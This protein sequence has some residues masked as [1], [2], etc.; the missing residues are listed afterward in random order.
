MLSSET[1]ISIFSEVWDKVI[2]LWVFTCLGP[3]PC[4]SEFTFS[5]NSLSLSFSDI[6]VFTEVWH[7][8][9]FWWALWLSGRWV[10]ELVSKNGLGSGE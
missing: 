2:S 9:V 7:K 10:S 6:C 1:N 5:G 4:M 8:V 3:V